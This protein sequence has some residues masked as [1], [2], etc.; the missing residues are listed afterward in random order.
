MAR[1]RPPAA[2]AAAAEKTLWKE[3]RRRRPGLGHL[4][5]AEWMDEERGDSESRSEPMAVR[6]ARR[7]H[8]R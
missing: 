3:R 6:L 4:A 1:R 2:E 5:A 8:G 7:C